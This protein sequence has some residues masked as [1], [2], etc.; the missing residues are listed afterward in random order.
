MEMP[1][2]EPW[3]ISRN[4]NG[5]K[6]SHG[7]Q[8]QSHKISRCSKLNNGSSREIKMVMTHVM[9]GLRESDLLY[10]AAMFTKWCGEGWVVFMFINHLFLWCFLMLILNPSNTFS[11]ILNLNSPL[12]MT[13][14]AVSPTSLFFTLIAHSTSILS[15]R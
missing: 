8:I 4:S 6:F 5:H 2:I 1:E 13:S 7:G 15:H 10:Y 12:S 14:F 11:A 9:W 3:K